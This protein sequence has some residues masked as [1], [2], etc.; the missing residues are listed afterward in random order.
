[1]PIPEEPEV[2][3]DSMD[4]ILPNQKI[5]PTKSMNTTVS[6]DR[7][8]SAYPVMDIAAYHSEREPLFNAQKFYQSQIKNPLNDK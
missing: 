5:I 7:T 6:L 8:L 1:V 3:L 2:L 4:G